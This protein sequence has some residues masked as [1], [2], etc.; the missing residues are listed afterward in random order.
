MSTTFNTFGAVFPCS[1]GSKSFNSEKQQQMFFRLHKK[2]CAI[3]AGSQ[4]AKFENE[5]LHLKRQEYNKDTANQDKRLMRV[6][7]K[8]V[9]CYPFFE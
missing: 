3:C 5:E 9:D 2:K 8:A 1:L 6:V 4:V 7:E